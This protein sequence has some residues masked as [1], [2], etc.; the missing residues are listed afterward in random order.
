MTIRYFE[1]FKQDYY[2]YGF[3]KIDDKYIK[4]L[5]EKKQDWKIEIDK[6][7]QKLLDQIDNILKNIK[8]KRRR[9]NSV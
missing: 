3:E 5:Q 6:F 1:R 7:R 9:K 4:H 8:S 2:N